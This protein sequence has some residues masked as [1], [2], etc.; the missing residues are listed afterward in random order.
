MA[1]KL[2]K[3]ASA[4]RFAGW[5]KL[6]VSAIAN[7]HPVVLN[8]LD[9]WR[10]KE[11]FFRVHFACRFL[12]SQNRPANWHLASRIGQEE[13]VIQKHAA[14]K[15]APVIRCD[16][17]QTIRELRRMLASLTNPVTAVVCDG[18][19]FF[20]TVALLTSCAPKSTPR[21]IIFN[22]HAKRINNSRFH[23]IE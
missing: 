7:F 3:F 8:S 23:N 6:P 11:R 19:K 17:R 5:Q 22:R 20:D 2:E 9:S 15:L 18:L 21:K 12:F 10:F 14:P 4:P 1:C 13:S 16:P